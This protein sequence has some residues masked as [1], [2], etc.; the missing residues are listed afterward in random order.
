[1]E[2]TGSRTA[3]SNARRRKLESVVDDVLLVDSVVAADV[4]LES[5]LLS[6]IFS[7]T[8]RFSLVR[9]ARLEGI[10]ALVSI[11]ISRFRLRVCLLWIFGRWGCT[12]I[13]ISYFS[14]KDDTQN[15]PS[16]CVLERI[17]AETP[18]GF[19]AGTCVSEIAPT[20]CKV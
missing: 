12:G 13:Y 17:D 4:D 10:S 11:D 16:D 8:L 3:F 19:Q 14:L 20:D 15:Q 18:I 2:W 1:M 7:K 5:F 6:S 9:R